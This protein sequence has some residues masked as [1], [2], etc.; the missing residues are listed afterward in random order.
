MIQ[1]KKK[2]KRMTMKVLIIIVL[3]FIMFTIVTGCSISA[4]RPISKVPDALIIQSIST[5]FES[6]ARISIP[7]PSLGPLLLLQGPFKD[8]QN[9]INRSR[10]NKA[11]YRALLK[12]AREENSLLGNVDV[13]EITWFTLSTNQT[14]PIQYYATGT[15][16]TKQ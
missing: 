1:K 7:D 4:Y 2:E 10:L 16:I 3:T 9:A 12:K 15:V 14:G 8:T 11:A 5:T 13:H 6:N